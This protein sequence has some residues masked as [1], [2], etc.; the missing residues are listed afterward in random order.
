MGPNHF[1]KININKQWKTKV[2]GA[3]VENDCKNN[4]I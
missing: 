1:L 2:K 3:N 4:I